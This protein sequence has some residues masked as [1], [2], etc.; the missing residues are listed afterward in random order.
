[1]TIWY[2][3]ALK[4][5]AISQ[6][7]RRTVILNAVIHGRHQYAESG[8]EKAR[9]VDEVMENMRSERAASL[10]SVLERWLRSCSRTGVT[11][12]P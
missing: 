10:G 4:P 3:D 2:P 8:P 6:R 12:S 11:Q 9:L 1:M 7:G 5:E